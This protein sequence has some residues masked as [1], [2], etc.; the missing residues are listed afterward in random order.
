[1]RIDP[2]LD[3]AQETEDWANKAW[4]VPLEDRAETR[5]EQWV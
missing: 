3:L 1:M 2:S 5:I 4:I